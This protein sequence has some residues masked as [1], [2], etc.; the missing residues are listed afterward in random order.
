ML[1]LQV[2]KG[3]TIQYIHVGIKGLALYL[4]GSNSNSIH[5]IIT[6]EWGKGRSGINTFDFFAS[7]SL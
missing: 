7:H 4:L 1:D 2:L 6:S 3:S 5:H